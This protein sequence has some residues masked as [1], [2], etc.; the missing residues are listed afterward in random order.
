M[1][2]ETLR[3]VGN[4]IDFSDGYSD[5]LLLKESPRGRI[6]TATRAG[7]RFILK[8]AAGDGARDI[9]A[10]KRE[11]EMTMSITHPFIIYVFTY[12]SESPVGPCIVMEYVDGRTLS[13]WLSERPSRRERTRLFGQLLDAIE[14]LHAKGLLHNDLSAENILV[15]RVGNSL[16]LI[17]FGFSDDDIH[18]LGRERGC[19]RRYASGELLAGSPA[20]ARSDIYSTGVLM[21]EIFGRRFIRISRRACHK[22]PEHRYR[23]VTALR[24]AW[25]RARRLPLCLIVLLALAGLSRASYDLINW[26]RQVVLTQR[27][28]AEKANLT[29]SFKER[30]D[31]YYATEVADAKEKISH[32]PSNAEAVAIWSGLIDKYNQFWTELIAECPE[33][34]SAE[35]I[36]HIQFKYNAEF[37]LPPQQ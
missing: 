29:D 1:Q 33:D 15:N 25:L 17:D 23:S 7:K 24:K 32:A 19:T 9:E 3:E 31:R 4:N 13:E 28:M 18:Y 26:K 16:K 36:N 27:E 10:L 35:L 30:V 12:E 2:S 5:I 11:Y 21:R 6:Y 34:C 14:Y 20:D 8:A 22:T 37:P